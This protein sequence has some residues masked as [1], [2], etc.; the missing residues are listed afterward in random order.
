MQGQEK[1][2]DKLLESQKIVRVLAIKPNE[3]G[4]SNEQVLR[5]TKWKVVEQMSEDSKFLEVGFNLTNYEAFVKQVIELKEQ[6]IGEKVIPVSE[7]FNAII[8]QY[9]MLSKS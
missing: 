8:K 3:K 2:G 9:I 4:K 5:E 7:E 1:K 6:L